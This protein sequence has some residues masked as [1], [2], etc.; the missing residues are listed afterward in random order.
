[1]KRIIISMIAAAALMLPA[2]AQKLVII[3]TNDTHSQI[4]TI[5]TGRNAGSGGVDRRMNFIDSVRAKY[6]EKKVLLLD[7]GD[8]N[9]GTPYF[10]VGGGDLEMD[11]MNLLRYDA[12]SIGNH[13]FDNGQAE[14][15]RRLKNGNF[16]SLCCNYDFSGTPLEGC[17]QPYTIIKRGGFKIGIIGAVAKLQGVV[18]AKNLEGMKL[19]NTL[20]E[21]N[22]YAAYLKNEKKCDLVI[23]L[24]H[25]GFDGGNEK[26]PS[27][28][29]VAA[30][31]T[32]IDFIIG[33]HSHT[34]VKEPAEI[35][36]LN[37]DIVPIVQAGC[38]GI[39]VGELKIY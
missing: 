29:I 10:N 36:N 14:L 20:E 39:E 11:L 25:L 32:D 21:I 4:E 33:G 18:S 15:A 23:L 27:D 24:S 1:M 12:V 34:F 35:E 9:Q 16:P 2:N 6:G 37:G 3:H 38:K 19:L 22:R 5:R 30:N 26:N 13:E 7:A 28:H 31:S 17:V 8:Y